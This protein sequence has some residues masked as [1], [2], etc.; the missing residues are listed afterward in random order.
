MA[1]L[2]LLQIAAQIVYDGTQVP[3][4]AGQRRP[5]ADWLIRFLGLAKLGWRCLKSQGLAFLKFFRHLSLCCSCA[6]LCFKAELLC[7]A[8]GV[9]CIPLQAVAFLSVS[10]KPWTPATGEIPKRVV[11]HAA[12]RRP[13]TA[14]NHGSRGAKQVW[15]TCS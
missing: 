11:H 14:S 10:S 9:T 12:C 6:N 4:P 2:R 13:W 7:F 1:L 15:K 3:S 8:L 5:R